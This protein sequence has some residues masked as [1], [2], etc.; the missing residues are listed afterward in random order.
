MTLS[1]VIVNWNTRELLNKCLQSIYA[2]PYCQQSEIWVGDNASSDGSAHFVRTEFPQ[3]RLI[4]NSENLGFAAAN[5]RALR[6]SSSDKVL[7]LNPD[8]EVKLGAIRVLASF[9]D[10]NPQAGA[11]GP[12][13]IDSMGMAQVSVGEAPSLMGEFVRLFHLRSGFESTLNSTQDGQPQDRQVDVL[14]GA[15]LMLRRSAL[16][17]VGLLDEDYFMFSEEVDLCQRLR[18]AG[19]TIHW[20]PEA[21]VIHHGG[22]SSQQVPMESFLHLYRGK[23]TYF[24]KQHGT[25]AAIAYKAILVAASLARLFVTPLSLFESPEGRTRHLDLARQYGRLLIQMPGM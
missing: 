7:L 4:E 14:Q 22:Q 5:N 20:V 25:M 9:L 13:L 18:K 17:E 19:W 2:D 3:V 10:A 1:I 15:C 8:T 6:G 24:R 12:M 11:T 21:K 23:I 16:D